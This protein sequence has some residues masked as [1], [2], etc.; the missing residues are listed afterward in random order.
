MQAQL[1]ARLARSSS[2]LAAEADVSS[3]AIALPF[4]VPCAAALG[5]VAGAAVAPPLAPTGGPLALCDDV[6]DLDTDAPNGAS[7]PPGDAKLPS[8]PSHDGGVEGGSA[9]A[10]SSSSKKMTAGSSWE[11][12]ITFDC[13]EEPEPFSTHGSSSAPPPMQDPWQASAEAVGI[14]LKI[15]LLI[16]PGMTRQGWSILVFCAESVD[17]DCPKAR[18]GGASLAAARVFKVPLDMI[19][20]WMKEAETLFSREVPIVWLHATRPSTFIAWLGAAR[21][22]RLAYVPPD[23]AGD[24]QLAAQ[25]CKEEHFLLGMPSTS[26]ARPNAASMELVRWF[27]LD[28]PRP[29][30]AFCY[31]KLKPLFE[32]GGVMLDGEMPPTWASQWEERASKVTSHS[33]WWFGQGGEMPSAGALVREQTAAGERYTHA[34]RERLCCAQVAT[35]RRPNCCGPLGNFT[36]MCSD[37]RAEPEA[38]LRD[39]CPW[40][41][42]GCVAR[43]LCS[44][45]RGEDLR[46]N[47]AIHGRDR[48]GR[49]RHSEEAPCPGGCKTK[50]KYLSVPR[51]NGAC[52]S[53]FRRLKNAA[54][55]LAWGCEYQF[56]RWTASSTNTDSPT[57]GQKRAREWTGE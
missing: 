35:S 3:S 44:R 42:S 46:K 22:R 52:R 56:N 37:C 45:C 24:A 36:E 43:A 38:R 53:G 26:T 55:R 12:A 20:D 21:L 18:T 8:T 10:L 1:T 31:L 4:G 2:G 7:P 11:A 51:S 14:I 25:M 9:V 33:F 13:D 6:V 16:Q 39:H 29:Q 30:M 50:S 19:V 47:R 32:E 34:A 15:S 48:T 54:A 27:L 49:A 5:G 41:T 57:T 23:A 40:A 28:K 17:K